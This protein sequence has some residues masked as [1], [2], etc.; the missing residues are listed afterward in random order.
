MSYI[1]TI[2][3]AAYLAIGYQILNNIPWPILFLFLEPYNIK[4][5]TLTNREECKRIQKKITWWSQQTD[6]NKGCGYSLGYWY[7]IHFK[8]QTGDEDQYIVYM[9]ATE[10]SYQKLIKENDILLNKSIDNNINNK[11]VSNIDIYDRLGSYSNIWFK[12]RTMKIPS[13]KPRLNQQKILDTII[14]QY[15]TNNSTVIFLH[16]NPGCGKSR[17]GLFIAEYYKGSYCNN[18]TPWQPGDTLSNLYSEVDPT[19]D[20]PLI[21]ALEE[22]D[23]PLIKIHNSEIESHKHLP[24]LIKDKTGWNHFF[25][26][27]NRGL[28]PNLIILMTSNKSPEYVN[29]LDPSYL[30]KGRVDLIFELTEDQEKNQ[31]LF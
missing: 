7:Y 17:M 27:I 22:I 30:R 18:L 2:I 8:I 12:K 1:H 4:Y 28:F 3:Q 31:N 25:D 29:N 11:V 9:I 19:E 16:G 5:Y 13:I 20:K 6:N 23:I 24:V 26:T 10:S 15:K 21:V 14:E